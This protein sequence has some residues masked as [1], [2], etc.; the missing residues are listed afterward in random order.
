[1]AE[2]RGD[3]DGCCRAFARRGRDR[4]RN[5]RR[6]HRDHGEIGR[7]PADRVVGFDRANALDGIVVRI[8]QLDVAGKAAAAQIFEH[9]TARSIFRAGLAP[10]TATDRGAN[11]LS[12]R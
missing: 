3:D 4:I 9:G 1:M 8:D 2:T 6:R 10:T 5:G 7:A 11:A 12:S